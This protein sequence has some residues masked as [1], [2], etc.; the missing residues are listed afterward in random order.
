MPVTLPRIES[1]TVKTHRSKKERWLV[2][3]ICLG[4]YFSLLSCSAP[5]YGKLQPSPEITRMFEDQRVLSDYLYYFSGPQGVP[6]AII[7]IQPDYS[8]SSNS[9]QQVDL[10]PLMLEKWVFRMRIVSLIN[11]QGA[12]ILGPEGNRIGIWF[13]SHNHTPVRLEENNRLIVVPPGPTQLQE[14]R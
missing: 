1:R 11:P 10:T 8:L 6:D 4:F 14:I 2:A 3:V 5:N 13:S 12:W 9:W 7:G